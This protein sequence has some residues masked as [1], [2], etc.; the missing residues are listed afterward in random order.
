[1]HAVYTNLQALCMLLG[2]T[3]FVCMS[4]HPVIV[5]HHEACLSAYLRHVWLSAC[6]VM[7]DHTELEVHLCLFIAIGEASTPAERK[8]LS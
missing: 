2:L 3:D 6:A 7:L 4:I 8:Q 1:M 5:S